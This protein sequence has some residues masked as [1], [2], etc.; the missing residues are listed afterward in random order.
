[1]FEKH[2]KEH[3]LANSLAIEIMRLRIGL[4]ECEKKNC[5]NVGLI[6]CPAK[7]IIDAFNQ[8]TER[9]INV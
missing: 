9:L 3:D 6:A 8:Y 4:K 5:E 1:M 2:T 7:R